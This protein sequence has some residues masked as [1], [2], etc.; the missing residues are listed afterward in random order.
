MV[1]I[2]VLIMESGLGGLERFD[3]LEAPLEL[4]VDVLGPHGR[5]ENLCIV[6]MC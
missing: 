3:R 4:S 2:Q 6:L 5:L 1:P